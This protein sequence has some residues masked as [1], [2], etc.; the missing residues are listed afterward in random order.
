MRAASVVS[1]VVAA[2]LAALLGSLLA[3]CSSSSSSAF[4][5]TLTR[6]KLDFSGVTQP[7]KEL[8]A[9]D[10]VLGQLPPGDRRVVSPVRDYARILYG[11]SGWSEDQKLKFLSRF[12]KSDAP[13]LDRRLRSECNVPLGSRIAPFG[14]SAGQTT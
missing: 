3:G 8:R 10:Q 13:A 6:S 7:T 4:C 12:F 5:S 1:P 14:L 11:R 2:L 9:L